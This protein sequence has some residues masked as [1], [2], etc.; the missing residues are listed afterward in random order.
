MCLFVCTE[1]NQVVHI[2][3][4]KKAVFGSLGSS[5][6]SGSIDSLLHKD[7][8]QARVKC[9]TLRSAA[10]GYYDHFCLLLYCCLFVLM[11]FI[12]ENHIYI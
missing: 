5:S 8:T 11:I 12:D 6:G 4:T 2:T 9:E 3:G 10:E 7:A 1:N